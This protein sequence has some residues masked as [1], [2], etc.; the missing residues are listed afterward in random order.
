MY[1]VT[2]GYLV[3]GV[4]SRGSAPGG[5]GSAPGEGGLLQGGSALEGEV[6]AGQ[7]PPPPPVHRILDTHL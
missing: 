7:V 3:P 4:C 1:L 6:S 5:G 2:G